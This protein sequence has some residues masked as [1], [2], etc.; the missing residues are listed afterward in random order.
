[1]HYPK[2][3]PIMSKTVV[4]QLDEDEC[5]SQHTHELIEPFWWQW[6]KFAIERSRRRTK[7]MEKDWK[8]PLVLLEIISF[9]VSK[10]FYLYNRGK[11]FA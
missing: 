6:W 7:A 1:M 11:V 3:H 10:G 5:S 2:L 8:P 4:G 9:F